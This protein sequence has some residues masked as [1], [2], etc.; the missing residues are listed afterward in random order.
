MRYNP[1]THYVDRGRRHGV[2]LLKVKLKEIEV[3]EHTRWRGKSISQ[4]TRPFNQ[5]S[6][7][8]T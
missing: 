1:L 7:E 8:I 2:D 5:V 3:E 4:V 6:P